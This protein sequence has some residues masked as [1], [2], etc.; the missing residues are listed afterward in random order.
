[1][2]DDVFHLAFGDSDVPL[3]DAPDYVL[4]RWLE[5]RLG[6][7]PTG[8]EVLALRAGLLERARRRSTLGWLRR[9]RRPRP[10]REEKLV[11]DFLGSAEGQLLMRLVEGGV[12]AL[13]A[14]LSRPDPWAPYSARHPR[15]HGFDRQQALRERISREGRV[16]VREQTRAALAYID[17][18]LTGLPSVSPGLVPSDTEFLA[19]SLA[20][21]VNACSLPAVLDF[22]NRLR[23]AGCSDA[24]RQAVLRDMHFIGREAMRHWPRIEWRS[25][26]PPAGCWPLPEEDTVGQETQ[27]APVLA[28]TL[29]P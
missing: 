13:V 25:P 29:P 5:R 7:P 10:P 14:C 9:W 1:M 23:A 17:W 22:S 8:M 19:P 21:A 28:P 20:A 16:P 24:A 6:R 27:H 2:T 3:L 18:K 12:A 4:A 26:G 15:L 11:A